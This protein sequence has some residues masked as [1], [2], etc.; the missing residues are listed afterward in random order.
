MQPEGGWLAFPFNVAQPTFHLGRTGAV[1][2]P[3]TDFIKRSNHDYYFL[4]T[5]MAVV[6]QKGNGFGLNTPNAPAVSLDRPGLYR[7]TPDFIPQRPN[8]FVN[9]F[10]TQWGTNFTEWVEG[11]LSANIYLWSVEDYQNEPSLITPTEETRVPLMAV[12]RDGKGGTLPVSAEGI[13]LSK[14]GVLVT[15][16]GANPDGNGDVLRIWE[17]AGDDGKCVITL[18]DC[19]YRTARYCDLRGEHQGKAF[20]IKQNKITVNLKAYQPLSLILE[21]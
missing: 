21:K 1:V 3:A 20:P 13:Q 17:Q 8:V 16:F 6:D 5:G 7:F 18:P 2:N 15:A 4:N 10:N 12:Y 9:L 14:K 11:A 19:G